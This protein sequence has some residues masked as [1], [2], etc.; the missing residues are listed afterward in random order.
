MTQ[1]QHLM[2]RKVLTIDPKATLED[3]AWGLTQRGFTGAPVKDEQGNILGILSKSDLA[4]ATRSGGEHPPARVADAMTPVL[5]AA[6]TDD[7]IRFA[8]ERMV[9]TGTHRLVVVDE[10]GE[11]VG[12]IT[13]MDILKGLLDGRVQPDDFVEGPGSGETRGA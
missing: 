12:I 11:L 10:A 2:T 3:A 1:V 4:N 9:K 5:F 6:R 13:P 7:P 8:A